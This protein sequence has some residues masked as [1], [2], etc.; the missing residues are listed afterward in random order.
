[1]EELFWLCE[2]AEVG[3][4]DLFAYALLRCGLLDSLSA[5]DCDVL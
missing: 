2:Q 4:N 5:V 1:M 3:V